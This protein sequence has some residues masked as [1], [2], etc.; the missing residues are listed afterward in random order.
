MTITLSG[1]TIASYSLGFFSSRHRD[2]CDVV[3]SLMRALVKHMMEPCAM[4]PGSPRWGGDEIEDF[5]FALHSPS[6]PRWQD[7]HAGRRAVRPGP[8]AKRVDGVAVLGV[9]SHTGALS[10]THLDLPTLYHAKY[11]WFISTNMRAVIEG[12]KNITIVTYL[13]IGEWCSRLLQVGG[14]RTCPR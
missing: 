11:K 9:S 6:Q 14:R 3:F 4:W 12:Q 13:H 2:E 5:L 8:R 1:H 10:T 7:V